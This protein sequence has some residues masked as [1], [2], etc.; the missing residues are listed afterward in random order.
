[1][2]YTESTLSM[3]T[4]LISQQAK[5]QGFTVEILGKNNLILHKNT[6]YIHVKGSRT[7]FQSSI[8]VSTANNKGLTKIF[9]SRFNIPTAKHIIV[10]DFE[11]FAKTE[12]LELTFPIVIKPADG[13]GGKNVHIGI[14]HLAE[15]KKIVSSLE[16][17]AKKLILEEMLIGDEYRVTCVDYKVVAVTMRKPAFVT[18]DGVKTIGQLIE[19]K[20]E[21]HWRG[22]EVADNLPLVKIK[23]NDFLIECLDEQK[24]TLKTIQTNKNEVYLRKN[25]NI[26]TGGEGY[27]IDLKNIHPENIKLFEKITK[28]CD[29][30]VSGIDIM[31]KDLSVPITEQNNAGV[32]EVNA[33]PG[34]D[35]PEFP[36]SGTPIN[37]AEKI[38]EMIEKYMG[39]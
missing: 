6:S 37:V 21:H 38:V 33:S 32:V 16:G 7:S 19:E 10:K 9:L 36:M 27:N 22:N 20:N 3:S 23:I 13:S 25:S 30:N 17:K 29:L 2:K 8:G 12:H 35:V 15:A 24:L 11:V 5:K 39:R 34:I 18:G 4:Y 1:M 28:V 14:Q 31:C 26:S